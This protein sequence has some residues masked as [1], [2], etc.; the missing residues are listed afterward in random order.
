MHPVF[1]EKLSIYYNNN[2]NNNNNRTRAT[3][4][5]GA[6]DSTHTRIRAAD[7]VRNHPGI[8]IYIYIYFIVCRFSCQKRDTPPR[9]R[10]GKLIP[11]PYHHHLPLRAVALIGVLR[12]IKWEKLKWEKLCSNK[13]MQKMLD[14]VG[15]YCGQMG[16][17][18]E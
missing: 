1:V 12:I 15:D 18:S 10:A 16:S 5:V 3:V 8:Y 14:A 9:Q 6:T 17:K 4:S 11:E 13:P 2:N 7:S